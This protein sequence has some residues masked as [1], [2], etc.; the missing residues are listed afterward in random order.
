MAAVNAHGR[1]EGSYREAVAAFRAWKESF[2]PAFDGAPEDQPTQWAAARG[3][4]S[5]IWW[6]KDLLVL[7]QRDWEPKASEVIQPKLL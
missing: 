7:Y 2:G 1:F 6:D 5:E 4:V 3:L